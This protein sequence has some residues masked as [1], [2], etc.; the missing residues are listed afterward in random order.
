MMRFWDDG[1]SPLDIL[2]FP[3]LTVYGARCWL[4]EEKNLMDGQSDNVQQ[5]VFD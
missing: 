5:Q 4:K 2:R 1:S 3:S